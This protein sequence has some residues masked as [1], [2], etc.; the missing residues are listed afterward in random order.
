MFSEHRTLHEKTVVCRGL[1]VSMSCTKKIKVEQ[2]DIWVSC[3]KLIRYTYIITGLFSLL[4]DP[5]MW[6]L[7]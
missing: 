4:I 1:K 3:D 5:I 6:A 2:V 7:V